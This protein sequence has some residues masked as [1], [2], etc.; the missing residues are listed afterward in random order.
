MFFLLGY[1]MVSEFYVPKF[2]RWEINQKKEY[3]TQNT[4]KVWNQENTISLTEKTFNILDTFRFD[5][6]V[7][8]NMLQKL[9]F[10]SVTF[11][12]TA[13]SV[14]QSVYCITPAITLL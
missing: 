1:S 5:K 9:L 13:E 14:L 4:A 8:V 10:H 3:N 7:T 2:R 11:L 6:H 12:F